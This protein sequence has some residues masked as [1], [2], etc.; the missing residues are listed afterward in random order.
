MRVQHPEV[1]TFYVLKLE[2]VR[3]LVVGLNFNN[4]NFLRVWGF[5]L[6]FI[7]PGCCSNMLSG[8]VG[9]DGP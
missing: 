1:V 4:R 9:M 5:F 2:I 7:D 6:F 3:V 8:K